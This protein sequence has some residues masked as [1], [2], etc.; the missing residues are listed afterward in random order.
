M[1]YQAKADS[2]RQGIETLYRITARTT[3]RLQNL[4]PRIFFVGGGLAVALICGVMEWKG[5]MASYETFCIVTGITVILLGIF[6][7]TI[8]AKNAWR[9]FRRRPEEAT[10]SFE[11]KRLVLE[12]NG[13]STP[14]SYEDLHAV[15]QTE[16]AYVVYLTARKGYLLHQA[17]FQKGDP[18]T[19]S[20]FLN[21]RRK[22]P[23]EFF[24]WKPSK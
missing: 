21:K 19:L 16:E 9:L 23:V 4:I 2:S 13:T 5:Q 6:G 12:V 15:Y 1:E 3:M 17:D 7:E 24:S 20:V 18:R 10:L 22:Q 11:D 8:N 14:V